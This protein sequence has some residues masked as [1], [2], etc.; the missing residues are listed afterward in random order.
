MQ[1]LRSAQTVSGA[2]RTH[3]AIG[4][5]AGEGLRAEQDAGERREAVGLS[6][7]D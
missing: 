1:F 6:R 7:I 2:R 3:Q 4:S 5:S